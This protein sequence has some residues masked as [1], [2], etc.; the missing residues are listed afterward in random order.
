MNKLGDTPGGAALIASFARSI[1]E[2]SLLY[3]GT[4]DKEA[5]ANLRRYVLRVTPELSIVI[6]SKLATE[7]MRDFENTVMAEKRRLERAGASRA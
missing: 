7:M 5:E 1:R 4:D 6:G 3:A 2:L